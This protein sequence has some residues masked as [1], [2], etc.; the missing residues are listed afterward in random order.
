MSKP[1][2]LSSELTY[3]IWCHWLGNVAGLPENQWPFNMRY[4]SR[5]QM[6]HFKSWLWDHSGSIRVVNRKYHISA[7]DSDATMIA[8]RWA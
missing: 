1:I 3:R 5:R 2:L 4:A 7:Y 6:E 8:L